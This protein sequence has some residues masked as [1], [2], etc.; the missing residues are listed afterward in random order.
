MPRER[1]IGPEI[2]GVIFEPVQG[3]AGAF[4]LSHDFIETLAGGNVSA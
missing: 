2:A 4:N 1:M 3:V